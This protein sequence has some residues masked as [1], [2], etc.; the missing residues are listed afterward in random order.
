MVKNKHY[1]SVVTEKLVIVELKAISN[2]SYFLLKMKKTC[3][4][5]S[6]GTTAF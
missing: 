6:C 3:T 1:D 5:Y 2:V 4:T